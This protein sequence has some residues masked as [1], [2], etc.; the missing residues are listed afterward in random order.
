VPNDDVPNP[1]EEEITPAEIRGRLEFGCW[2]TLA[3]A[4]FLYWVNGPAVSQD[5]LVV[6]TSLML[7]ATC[8]A[9]GLRT[10]SWLRRRRR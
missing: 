4:P 8:G 7:I 10:Y 1:N 6:R 2:T 3:L 5:Q 9:I